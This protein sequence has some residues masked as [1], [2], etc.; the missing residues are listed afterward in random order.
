MKRNMPVLFFSLLLTALFFTACDD[1]RATGD[2]VSE[3]RSLS[4]YH[5]MEIA[6]PGRVEVRTDSVFRFEVTVEESVLPYLETYVDG[7]GTLKVF[8]SR[9]V[10]DVDDLR[11]RVWAPQWDGFRIEGSADLSVPAPIAGERLDLSIAGS[12]DLAIF[13][14]DFDEIRTAIAGSG[15]LE[16][17]G[18]ANHFDCSVAGSGDVE[19]LGCPVKTAT[20]SVSGSGDVRVRVSDQLHA[21]ISGSGNIEYEGEPQVTS[22]VSG[23]GHVRKI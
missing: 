1:T 6:V 2:L 17:S 21:T 3:T 10:W 13:D 18:V 5:A 22:Q 4:D 23:S 7:D 8:F 12:G 14:A 9:D 15:D 19:A 11:I 16:L 20:V